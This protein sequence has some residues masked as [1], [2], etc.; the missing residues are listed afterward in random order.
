[1]K[2]TG[3]VRPIDNLG[4]VVLPVELRKTLGL[5]VRDRVEIYV[6]DEREIILKKYEPACII[7]DCTDDVIVYE[8][9]QICKK[10]IDR[11]KEIA[12]NI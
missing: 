1:M 4:R 7:C 2:A 12:D 3:T 6:G 10:C 8:G 9:K 11:M 5:S